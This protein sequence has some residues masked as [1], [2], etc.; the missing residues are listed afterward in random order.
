MGAFLK[1]VSWLATKGQKYVKIAW[2]HKQDIL[3]WLNAGQTF[4]WIYQ[5][6]KKLWA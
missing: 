3:N 1:F 5:K 6:I 2:A 4:D